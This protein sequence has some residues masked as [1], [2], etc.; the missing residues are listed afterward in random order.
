V[1][2]VSSRDVVLAFLDE[3]DIPLQPKSIYGGL[4]SN[5][6]ITFSYRTVQNIISEF[7]DEGLIE[8]VRIDTDE[9]V[10]EQMSESDSGRAYYLITD[11]GR[12]KVPEELSG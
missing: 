6:D 1:P 5:Q 12:Q 8:K 11:K 7:T 3:H 4:I 9:G 10:V 2:Q